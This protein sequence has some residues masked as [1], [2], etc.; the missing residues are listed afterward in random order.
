MVMSR[1]VAELPWWVKAVQ[2]LHTS[3]K[4]PRPDPLAL[5]AEDTTGTAG[6]QLQLQLQFLD[7]TELVHV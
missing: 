1:P 2:H 7:G 3:H 5:Q 6:K 4:G